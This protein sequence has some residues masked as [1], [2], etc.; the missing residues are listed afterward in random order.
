[1]ATGEKGTSDYLAVDRNNTRLNFDRFHSNTQHSRLERVLIDIEHLVLGRV[2]LLKD[3]KK[4]LVLLGKHLCGAATDLSLT[5]GL[6]YRPERTAAA[7]HF[8]EECIPIPSANSSDN[9]SA[10]R[11]RFEGAVPCNRMQL[12][13]HDMQPA[14]VMARHMMDVLLVSLTCESDTFVCVDGCVDGCHDMIGEPESSG[15]A[16]VDVH[17]AMIALCCHQVCEWHR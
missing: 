6:Q 14:A 7:A 12:A 4:P 1:M 8:H 2:P 9:S 3:T 16:C 5:C 13:M 17:G 15:A 11:Q 10:K